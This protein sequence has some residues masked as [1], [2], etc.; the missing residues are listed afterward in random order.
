MFDV[1]PILTFVVPVYRRWGLVRFFLER[2]AFL[3]D[4][5]IEVIFVFDDPA[6]VEAAA[7]SL[8][9]SERLRSANVRWLVHTRHHDWRTP[10]RA[11]NAGAFC[12]RGWTVAVA[13]PE[14]ILLP[15]RPYLDNVLAAAEQAA[16]GR[17]FFTGICETIS[18][19]EVELAD[20]EAVRGRV[21]RGLAG[22]RP[23]SGLLIVQ[24]R[25][26]LAA[27]GFKT[28]DESYASD[29]AEIKRRLLALGLEPSNTPPIYVANVW[30]W[31]AR[32]A[33]NPAVQFEPHE[34]R[35]PLGPE[36]LAE[37]RGP[38]SLNTVSGYK[39]PRIA[40]LTPFS[41]RWPHFWE[42]A[43]V[44]RINS[45]LADATIVL[46]DGVETEQWQRDLGID[47]VSV[48]PQPV[49][50]DYANRLMLLSRAIVHGCDWV[51]WMDD[52]WTFPD[53]DMEKL[54]AIASDAQK[55]GQVAVRFRLRDMWSDAEYRCDPPLWNNRWRIGLSAN[56][57][58]RPVSAWDEN[59]LKPLHA[60][61]ILS[62]EIAINESEILHWGMASRELRSSRFAR[63]LQLDPHN[64]YNHEGYYYVVDET[65]TR[66][67]RP[68]SLGELPQKRWEQPPR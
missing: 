14:S 62:G 15:E 19:P 31:S 66:L 61:P 22:R 48:H 38:Y 42:P 23:E 39:E 20:T 47:V 1:R 53:M 44:I 64:A 35:D 40:L 17:R 8:R 55:K 46:N 49:W 54:R 45:R 37:Y 68:R 27:G 43:E 51:L 29:D 36:S 50:N 3:L 58:C 5:R 41:R 65:N 33:E 32:R 2:N 34:E 10:A 67:C 13:S 18:L 11:V 60:V 7:L 6:G 25:A 56:P 28:S 4:R 9:V 21:L 12:A 59:H 24:R 16:S 30:W 57:L 52:D 26:L 63:Y